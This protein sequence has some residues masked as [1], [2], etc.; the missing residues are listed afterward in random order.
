MKLRPVL[1]VL[2]ILC[3]FYFLTT[4]WL[5]SGA[6]A[7]LM[8]HTPNNL[9]GTTTP[10][11]SPRFLPHRSQRR[12]RLRHRRAPE[13]RRLQ[14]SP[15]VGRK[16]HQHRSRLLRLLLAPSPP[17]GPGLRLH[18]RQPGPYPHQLP[19]HRRRPDRRGHALEQEEVQS[20]P[21]RGRPHP[22]HRAP[23]DPRRPRTSSLPRSLTPHTSSSASA[24][25]PSATRSASPAP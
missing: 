15:P 22:R 9:G 25:T 16:H 23:A 20:H 18:H 4:R 24:S 5:P 2:L 7:G 1:L 3:G 13:H 6:M 10:S 12:S 21:H 14:E 17:A 11:S 19:R 8:H